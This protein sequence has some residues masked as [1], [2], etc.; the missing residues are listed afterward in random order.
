LKKNKK[1]EKNEKIEIKKYLILKVIN[2]YFL[3]LQNVLN[4]LVLKIIFDKIK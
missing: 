3:H 2:K 4:F 1:V